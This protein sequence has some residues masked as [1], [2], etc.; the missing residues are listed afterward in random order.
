LKIILAFLLATTSFKLYAMDNNFIQ[1]T[2]DEL[3]VGEDAYRGVGVAVIYNGSARYFR[4]G[5]DQIAKN[6]IIE[7]G[8]NTK[9][10]TALLLSIAETKGKASLL[11]GIN[12]TFS[13]Q[14]VAEDVDDL[15]TL[16]SLANHS[17]GF[18]RLPDNLTSTDPKQPY[19]GFNVTEL[20]EYLK[21]IRW[22]DTEPSDC[23][24]AHEIDPNDFSDI[25]G[26]L[27][28]K[29]RTC[30]NYSNIGSAIL[31]H[32]VAA[33]MSK[34]YKNAVA[35][36]ITAP[37]SLSDTTLVLD[38]DQKSRKIQGYGV[39]GNPVAE[40]ELGAIAPAGSL[41]STLSDMSDFLGF[42]LVPPSA[43]SSDL[44]NAILKTMT[45]IE[46]LSI[47][48][49]KMT[50]GL[51]W[52]IRPKDDGSEVYWHTGGTSGFL[53]YM[54]FDKKN[55]TAVFIVGNAFK[56][57]NGAI[58]NRIFTAGAKILDKISL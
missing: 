20:K 37:F 21:S 18:P 44:Q 56:Q 48:E 6:S 11:S 45:E 31:G 16:K 23:T 15:I 12:E 27:L 52:H 55:Q 17:G 19:A 47:G 22:R 43:P 39:D 41:N 35:Q 26:H 38:E 5:N 9:V 51:G 28:R 29:S 58:D 3:T 42:Y 24:P 1:T 10:F 36:L 2:I 14:L 8:S 49:A 33:A 40:W 4:S 34:N 25:I 32:A 7:I 57:T 46:E 13:E 54:A 30:Y 50:L 53:S